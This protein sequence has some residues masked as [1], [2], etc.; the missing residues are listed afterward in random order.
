MDNQRFWQ[1]H[2][3]LAVSFALLVFV[4]LIIV[5]LVGVAFAL[6][7]FSRNQKLADERNQVQV[8]AIQIQ[9]THQLVQVAQQ[10][11]DIKIE[12]AKGIA[13]AQKIINDTLTPQYLQHEAIQSQESQSNKI[14][15]VPSGNQGI[16]LVQN[17]NQ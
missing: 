8:N 11:A 1:K 5:S 17:I 4:V 6:K 14:I 12:E 15:Y 2:E 10:K 9:Q 3:G 13:Q 7:S 16:P